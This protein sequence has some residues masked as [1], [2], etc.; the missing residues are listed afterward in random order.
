MPID[1]IPH[2][3][4]KLTRALARAEVH[5]LLAEII[6]EQHETTVAM[7]KLINE[8]MTHQGQ[9]IKALPLI[10]E[11]LKGH[12]DKLKAIENKYG[13][14]YKDLVKNEKFDG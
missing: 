9:I 11:M 6:I 14:P 3:I 1:L 12:G 10:N 5:P 4:E 7:Q 8:L 13:D 2:D